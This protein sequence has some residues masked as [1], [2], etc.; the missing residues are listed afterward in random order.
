MTRHH[1]AVLHLLDRQ[2]ADCEG[3]LVAKVD[4]VE[5]AEGDD[6]RL[7]VVALLTGP[8]ALGPHLG[9]RPGRPVVTTGGQV[10]G[11][12]NDVR[13][14][15]SVSGQPGYTVD[16]LV[17]S[18]RPV[19]STLG[20]DRRAEQ[21]PWLVGALVRALHRHDT[22]VPWTSVTDV[23]WKSGRIVVTSD[24]VRPLAQP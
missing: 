4:D 10:L 24:D 19:G 6:G 17:V 12:L 9:G 14:V 18:R 13:L 8:G 20:Y 15:P 22:L 7:R 21:G 3:R 23:D 2:L 16:A 1:D 5:L 11:R